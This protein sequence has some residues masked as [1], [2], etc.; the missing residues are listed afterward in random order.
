MIGLVYRTVCYWRLPSLHVIPQV[1]M[2]QGPGASGQ[3]YPCPTP[4]RSSGLPFPQDWFISLCGS[5]PACHMLHHPNV[6]SAKKNA[7]ER[8]LFFIIKVFGILH[9]MKPSWW[10][11][12]EIS[13]ELPVSCLFGFLTGSGGGPAMGTLCWKGLQASMELGLGLPVWL[14]TR[15]W[16]LGAAGE[17]V[18]R[19]MSDGRV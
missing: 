11:P 1:E 3:P 4:L 19:K 17:E 8:N 12:W 14:E 18:E 7:F 15:T 16:G 9:P 13:V 2:H 10:R 6:Q 5:K